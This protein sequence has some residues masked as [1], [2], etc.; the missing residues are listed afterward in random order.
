MFAA[1]LAC[2]DAYTFKR[3]TQMTN[4]FGWQQYY[5][6]LDWS[7]RKPNFPPFTV[8]KSLKDQF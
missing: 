8:T 2:A 3:P 6:L 7:W 1:V 5:G 4:S